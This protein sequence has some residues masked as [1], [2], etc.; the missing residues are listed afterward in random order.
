[1]SPRYKLAFRSLLLSAAGLLII[2]CG[3]DAPPAATAT[4]PELIA[5]AERRLRD[6]DFS[7][8]TASFR[9][10]LQSDSTSAVALFGLARIYEEVQRADVAERYRKRAFHLYCRLGTAAREASDRVA[11]RTAFAAA[12]IAMPDHPMAPL[13]IGETWFE[14]GL[15]DSA[16]AYFEQA[17]QANDRFVDARIKLSTAYLQ[18]GRM[19]EAQAGFE[20]VLELNV[21]A[22]EAYLSLGS[23]FAHR[24]EWAQAAAHYDRALLI[25]PG[26]EKAR[27]GL[28]TAHT[29]L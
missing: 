1:V 25:R 4:T 13:Q 23:I 24:G 26:S 19:D 28:Q 10:V 3:G 11:A 6:G 8:A 7:A 22:V 17:V 20:A 16:I 5:H 12:A 14:E 21:N 2:R 27:Q 18:S 15:L 29:H 9:R